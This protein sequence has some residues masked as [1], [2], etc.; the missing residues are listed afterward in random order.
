MARGLPRTLAAAAKTTAGSPIK[1]KTYTV[2]TAP[3]AASSARR[4]IY[5]SNGAAG[6]AVVAF[7]DGVNWKRLDTL[8][9]ISAT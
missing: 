1:L 8:A 5:V 6:A 9:N 4:L 2:A 7:S 3:S